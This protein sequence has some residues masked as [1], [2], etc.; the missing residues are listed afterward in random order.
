[1]TTTNSQQRTQQQRKRVLVLGAGLVA[2]PLLDELQG[3]GDVE[4]ELAAINIDRVHALLE[5]RPHAHGM[6]LDSDDREALAAAVD[7][8]QAV[9]SLLP[10]TLHIKVAQVCVERRKP[11]VTT[12]YVSDAMAALDAPAQAA[13]VLLLNECGLDP[14]I[15]HAMAS[16]AIRKV[17]LEGGSVLRFA[18]YCGGLPALEAGTNPWGYKFSWSPRGVLMAARSPVRYLRDGEVVEL[19][20]PYA[21]ECVTELEV[22]GIGNMEGYPNRDSL[23][24]RE[25][26][27]LDRAPHQLE[28]MIRG[29][30]R[31]AGWCATLRGLMEIGLLD[32]DAEEVAGLTYRQWLAR[33]LPKG[34]A[35]LV[36]RL[37]TALDLD[38]DDDVI[39]RIEWLGL[40][41][42]RP[43][44]LPPGVSDG[45]AAPLAA[46]LDILAQRMLAKL[47]YKPGERDMAL[48]E[49]ELVIRDADGKKRYRRERIL[50]IG[51]AGD[52]SAMATTVSIPAATACGLILDGKLDHLSGV[53]RPLPAEIARPILERLEA[54]GI[55]V[56]SQ[57]DLL[58][59]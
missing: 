50:A 45:Q 41:S 14:G 15:D 29:T 43:I 48:L 19:D 44:A 18:S 35:P 22:P 17:E 34:S 27:G 13:G 36:A 38:I 25:I 47:Q 56:E 59:D 6:K 57:E 52:D 51:L 20:T 16:E 53:H 21:P 9:V 11:L 33:K 42:E 24:Y 5:G 12:S 26:Y 30:L 39:S 2:K 8:A 3:R 55:A 46:P 4:I 10:A 28:G 58:G 7:R 1:M 31:Y 49:H 37:A 32:L 40:L 54:R 23:A